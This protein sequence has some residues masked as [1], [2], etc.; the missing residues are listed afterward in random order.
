INLLLAGI[1]NLFFL[2]FP[3][4]MAAANP[5][6]F[7]QAGRHMLLM[8]GKAMGLIIGLG[9]PATFAGVTYAVTKQWPPTVLAAF[10]PAVLIC[11]LPIPLVTFAFQRFD[12]SRDTPP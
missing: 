11:T 4:R 12:V 5:G 10:L 2:L 8:M 6:D 7:S 9:L 1:D 3:T